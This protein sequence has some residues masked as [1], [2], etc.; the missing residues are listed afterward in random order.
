MVHVSA[1]NA[2]TFDA[3]SKRSMRCDTAN[4]LGINFFNCE[5]E[6]ALDDLCARLEQKVPARIAFLNAHCANLYKR[7]AVYADALDRADVILPD[8]AGVALG[9][10]LSGQKLVANLNGTDFIPALCRRLS[11]SGHSVF[12]LGGQPGIAQ[13]AAQGLQ[14]AAPGLIIAGTHHGFFAEQDEPGLI[15]SINQSGAD[16][17]L[18]A[19]GV[20][21]QDIWLH[22][23]APRLNATLSFGVGGLFDFLSRRIPRAPALLRRAGLEWTY[24]LYQEPKR[25]FRRYIMGNPAFVARVITARLALRE[26]AESTTKRGLDIACAATGLALLALPFLAV[27]AAVRLTSPG[28]PLLRQIR[29]GENGKAFTL[30]KFRSMYRDADA[31]LLALMAQNQH[32]TDGVTFKMK[33]DPR[34]T[35]LGRLLRKSSIDELPQLLNVLNGSMS[36]VG[37]RPALPSEV[38]RY[39]AH[40]RD[41][42][43]GKPGITGLWQVSGRADIPFPRQVELDIEY[44]CRRNFLLDLGILLRT[45]PAVLLA[46]GAY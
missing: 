29:I 11:A 7:D 24:R 17:V 4:L 26:R 41:R 20:P 15:R 40:E 2:F 37:P 6:V 14:Q 36:L 22:R 28:S 10:R 46:R 8:G 38:A 33:R 31:R 12:L 45:V 1:S 34:V 42:L 13:A 43:R 5:E 21:K 3:V 19:M 35:M 27:M 44:L 9:L 23:V 16:V 30:Y 39:N 32:G 18:V 25:M